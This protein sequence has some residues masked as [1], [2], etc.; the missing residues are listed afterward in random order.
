MSGYGFVFPTDADL[1][2][3]RHAREQVRTIPT[4]TVGYDGSD[5]IARLLTERIAL[6]A[7]DAG[8]S[9]KPMSANTVDLRLVRIPLSS[10]DPWIALSDV[11]AQAG[12]PALKFNGGSVDDLYA[13]EQGTLATQRI[14]P[15]FHMPVSSAASATLKTWSMR[16]DGRW[17]LAD[18]WLG[19]GK[20]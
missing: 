5:P 15:L 14:I 16:S 9:L 1:P 19:S 11:A 12:L 17:S 8:L 6:N 18:A 2:R 3:A 4:W 10:V 20:P 13:A 7:K